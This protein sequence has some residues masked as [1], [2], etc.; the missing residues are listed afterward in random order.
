M[1]RPK[2]HMCALSI[3][4]MSNSDVSTSHMMADYLDRIGA[5]KVL[6]DRTPFSFDWT[7]PELIGRVTKNYVSWLR[8]SSGLSIVEPVVE[9]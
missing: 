2:T 1:R 4:N 9:R 8:C 5:G 3:A 7:P 6:L